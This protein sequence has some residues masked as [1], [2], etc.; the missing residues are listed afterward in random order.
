M[1]CSVEA[2]TSRRSKIIHIVRLCPGVSRLS[3]RGC[4][5][6]IGGGH[7][8]TTELER[9]RSSV[10]VRIE[11]G[12]QRRNEPRGRVHAFLRVTNQRAAHGDAVGQPPNCDGLLRSRNAESDADRERC[13]RAKPGD[14]RGKRDDPGT[15]FT[16]DVVDERGTHNLFE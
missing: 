3:T 13:R 8:R 7:A 5:P 16:A 10:C 9:R 12:A 6:N 4:S 11:R 15:M 1:L 2:A 14:G